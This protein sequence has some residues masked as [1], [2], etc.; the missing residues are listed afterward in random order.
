MCPVSN[1]KLKSVLDVTKHPIRE[2]F[3]AGVKVTVST[4]DPTVF[5]N[6]LVHEYD[7]LMTHLDFSKQEVIQVVRNGFDAALVDDQTRRMWLDE[8][9]TIESQL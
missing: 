3:D 9:A 2:F 1:V 4:D 8:L 7:L 6:D 5:G